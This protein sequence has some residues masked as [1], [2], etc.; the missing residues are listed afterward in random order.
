MRRKKG[1]VEAPR[2]EP[3]APEREVTGDGLTRELVDGIVGD[4]EINKMPRKFAATG[5]GVSPR[6]VERWI[7]KGTIGDGEPLHIEFAR[8]VHAAESRVVGETMRNLHGISDK[9]ARAGDY[10]LKAFKPG[11]F[12]GPKAEPD[13]FDRLERQ[14]SRRQSLLAKPPP[15]MLAELAAHGWWQF[16]VDVSAED[17]AVLEALQA[18]YRARALPEKANA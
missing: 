5:N 3:A 6:T 8:R 15:R 9:D 10:F 11:D 12:G 17:R 16:P 2:P 18:K 13:E 1:K 4:I 14:V 7:D